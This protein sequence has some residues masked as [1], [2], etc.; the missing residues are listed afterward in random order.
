MSRPKNLKRK[1]NDLSNQ[2]ELYLQL[3][4]QDKF[5]ENFYPEENTVS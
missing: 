5:L 3:F 1:Q 2:I 4:P